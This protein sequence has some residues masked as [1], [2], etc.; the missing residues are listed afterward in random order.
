MARSGK[1]WLSKWWKR[2]AADPAQNTPPPRY[3]KHDERPDY[4]G[5][6]GR[7]DD[8]QQCYYTAN[9]IEEMLAPALGL[10]PEDMHVMIGTAMPGVTPEYGPGQVGVTI[11]FAPSTSQQRM[12]EYADK[13]LAHAPT[14]MGSSA[15]YAID[16]AFPDTAQAL[17]FFNGFTDKP[18]L[19][20]EENGEVRGI[21]QTEEEVKHRAAHQKSHQQKVADQKNA[22][23]APPVEHCH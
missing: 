3:N 6:F 21:H 2:L 20:L 13:L 8:H 7:G 4:R 19:R 14:F 16:L 22:A 15:S 9:R 23:S 10:E 1:G 18:L 12:R 5:G 11:H 17:A